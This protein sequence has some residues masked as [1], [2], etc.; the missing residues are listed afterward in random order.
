MYDPNS[1]LG[2]GL[3]LRESQQAGKKRKTDTVVSARAAQLSVQN[4]KKKIRMSKWSR[5]RSHS[6]DR[7]HLLFPHTHTHTLHNSPPP[8]RSL[9]DIASLMKHPVASQRF[10]TFPKNSGGFDLTMQ[11]S[12]WTAVP[13][14]P[15]WAP[16]TVESVH[17]SK[18]LK[19]SSSSLPDGPRCSKDLMSLY[20]LACE[21]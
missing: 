15:P 20:I 18:V 1:V 16:Q 11:P 4:T 12:Q 14:G 9:L 19:F 3:T 13:A 21:Q 17:L 6:E 8:L 5:T 7:K 2:R 10:P